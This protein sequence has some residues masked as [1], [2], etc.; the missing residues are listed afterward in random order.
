MLAGSLKETQA[1]LARLRKLAATL[2]SGNAAAAAAKPA[3]SDEGGRLLNLVLRWRELRQQAV[4]RQ[5]A[6]LE[7]RERQLKA[8]KLPGVVE[9][10]KTWL[11]ENGAQVGHLLASA[12]QAYDFE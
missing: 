7:I 12:I 1:E 10:F 11:E 6:M 5:T 4:Q 9:T 2:E 3:A 8:G